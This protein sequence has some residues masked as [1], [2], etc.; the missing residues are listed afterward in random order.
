MKR[1]TIFCCRHIGEHHLLP[2]SPQ[3]LNHNQ[4]C[5]P[6]LPLLLFFPLCNQWNLPIPSDDDKNLWVSSCI[7]SFRLCLLRELF[8]IISKKK[9][10]I[11]NSNCGLLL[12]KLSKTCMIMLFISSLPLHISTTLTNLLHI[13][14]ELLKFLIFRYCT[15]MVYL[16]WRGVKIHMN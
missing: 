14:D 13:Y 10:F 4:C 16:H 15:Q 6:P 12:A 11:G 1:P 8:D 3:L 2:P 5:S 9:Y 7:F